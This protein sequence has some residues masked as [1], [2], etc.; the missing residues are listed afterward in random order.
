VRTHGAAPTTED[1]L[2][3]DDATFADQVAGMS[4]RRPSRLIVGGETL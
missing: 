4:I 2:E 1:D 3:E